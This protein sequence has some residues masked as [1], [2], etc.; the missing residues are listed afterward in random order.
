LIVPAINKNYVIQ[1]NTTGGQS[2]RVITAAGTGIT[3]PSGTTCAVYVDGTNVIQASDYAPTFTVGS[4]NVTTLDLTNLE[5]TNIK[6]KDGTASASIANSTGVMTIASSV[7]TTTDINGGTIDGTTVGASTASTGAFTTLGASGVATFSAGTV[8]APA[9]TTTGDTNTG[10]FFPAADTIAFSEGGVESVRITSVGDVGIGTSSP[11]AKLVV[12]DGS[13]PTIKLASASSGTSATDGFDI[14]ASGP[15]ALLYNRENGPMLFGTNNTERM[16]IDSAG[17]VGINVI[18][19]TWQAP[20]SVLQIGSAG[21]IKYGGGTNLDITNNAY[22]GATDWQ[23]ITTAVA[24]RYEIND[25]NH[26]WSS[27]VSGTAGATISWLER[28]RINSSGNVGIATATPSAKLQVVGTGRFTG[29]TENIDIFHNGTVGTIETT[30]NSATAITFANSGTERMRIASGGNVGVRTITPSTFLDVFNVSGSTTPALRVS[31]QDGAGD[32]N[33][34][35]GFY[36]TT[37][38]ADMARVGARYVSNSGG[39]FGNLDLYATY[40]GTCSPFATLDSY[41]NFAVGYTFPSEYVGTTQNSSRI[42]TINSGV[43]LGDMYLIKTNS[44]TT[45]QRSHLIHFRNSAPA[46]FARTDNTVLGGMYFTAS[47]PTSGVL[48]DAAAIYCTSEE[49]SG[50]STSSGL[51]FYTTSGNSVATLAMYINSGKYVGFGT[52]SPT[53]RIT[54]DSVTTNDADILLRKSNSGTANQ[55]GQALRFWNLHPANTGRSAGVIAGEIQ[56]AFSQ[57]TS[58]VQQTTAQI[59]ARADIEQAGTSTAGRLQFFTT[60]NATT[61]TF[62]GYFNSLQCMGVG[63][64]QATATRLSSYQYS[65]NSFTCVTSDGVNSTNYGINWYIDTAGH[66]IARIR[67][68]YNSSAALGYGDLVLQTNAGGGLR[69]VLTAADNGTIIFNLY[70]AGTLS[71]NSAGSISAS[72]GRYKTKTH[73]LTD[74]RSK[75]KQLAELATYYR[76][77]ADSP[78]GKDSQEEEIGWVA[79]DVGGVIPEASPEP[80]TPEQFRNYHDRAILAYL[81]KALAELAEEFEQYKAT[82]P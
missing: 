35:I 2:I 65:T 38:G 19:Q 66:S 42:L 18:P 79:Q 57:P 1:N 36:E 15:D 12:Y 69:D 78:W 25:N 62:A 47:Q 49:Q 7:L 23:Y 81:T 28:M 17:R 30:G 56:F 40:S 68:R 80:K 34:C 9:I 8:S 53:Y 70:G 26:I 37:K 10:I 52:R 5:V 29:G 46:G 14:L 82:H 48:Q 72:D 16:R 32:D 4:L 33:I 13:Q 63:S 74:A 31:A 51:G 44:G 11:S 54:T 71:T 64:E 77:N 59:I 45:N 61:S 60:N 24:D 75:I 22:F 21:A 58:G 50:N 73:G 67:G 3:V 20:I 39:G 41:G 76:W 55:N 27:A 43:G 6:A